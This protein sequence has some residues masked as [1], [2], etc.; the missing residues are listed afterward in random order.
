M[1]ELGKKCLLDFAESNRLKSEGI[2]F[3]SL[4]L[5]L[6]LFLFLTTLFSLKS[7]Y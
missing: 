5:S 3:F 4:S 2:P 7:F 6:Y 1:V